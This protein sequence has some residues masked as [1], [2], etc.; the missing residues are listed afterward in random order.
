MP[1]LYSAWQGTGFQAR[2]KLV[3]ALDYSADNTQAIFNGT[4]YVEFGGSINDPSNSWFRSGD[5]GSASGTNL[6]IN[7]PSGGGLEAITTFPAFNKYGDA[8]VAAAISGIAAV[9]NGLISGSFTLD[10]GPLAPY[11]TDDTYAASSIAPTSFAV[12]GYT[13]AGNG[14]TLNNVQVQYNV[15]TA[16]ATGA[17]TYTKGSYGTPTVSGL[18]PNTL[19]W[20]RVRISNSTY[21]YSAWGPWH[22]VRTL[23]TVPGAPSEG[24]YYAS[25][26]QTTAT[27][28]GNSVSDDGGSAVTDWDVQYN[29]TASATGATTVTTGAPT[30]GPIT[31]LTPGTTYYARI[32][33]KNVNGYGAYSSWKQIQMLPGVSVRVGG[34]WKTA[35]PFVNVNGVWKPATRFV[36]VSGV[37][38]Q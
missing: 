29:T 7:V 5:C 4:F 37:W 38:K 3:Y 16:S 11:F 36:R 27:I 24:W 6:P 20:F 15:G 34:V 2:I 23:S 13:G 21:G 8:T 28:G 32:R 9:G 1:I 30:V 18:T 14:G 10:A 35:I 17:T 19:Y 33:A 31:G 25:V 12:T 22:S 26:S